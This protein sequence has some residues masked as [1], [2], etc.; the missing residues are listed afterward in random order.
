MDTLP[1]RFTHEPL[2]QGPSRDQ[3]VPVGEMVKEYYKLRGWDDQGRP[4]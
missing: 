1:H 2:E 4:R 3:V